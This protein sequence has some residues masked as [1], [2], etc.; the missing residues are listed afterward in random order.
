VLLSVLALAF[1]SSATIN[2]QVS[3]SSAGIVQDKV[4]SQGA[5]D[6]IVG[7]LRQ[8]VVDGTPASNITNLAPLTYYNGQ[9]LNLYWPQAGQYNTVM[10]QV[11]L[12]N[13][14]STATGM[15]N[16]VKE[17]AYNVSLYSGSAYANTGPSRASSMHTDTPSQNGHYFNS[18]RWNK[19]LLMQAS[20]V[21]NYQPANP[22]TV[23]DWVLVGRDGSN[24]LSQGSTA[25]FSELGDPS[26]SDY[27]VGRYAFTIYDEGSL[28]DANVAGFPGSL[29]TEPAMPTTPVLETASSS[30]K[31]LTEQQ[32]GPK[33]A[34]SFADLSILN[35]TPAQIDTLVGW[36]NHASSQPSGSFP[37]YSYPNTAGISN[38]FGS[39]LSN[40][41]G[42]MSLGNVVNANNTAYQTD[43]SFPTRQALLDFFLKTLN[44]NSDIKVLD[45]LQY[46][47]TH[48]IDINQPSYWPDPER[49][50]IVG[51]WVSGTINP[52]SPNANWS[53]YQGNNDQAGNDDIDNPSFL[54]I[55]VGAGGGPSPF[56]RID[57]SIANKGD[58][59]VNKRFP[60]CRLAWLT[61]LGPSAT[62][63][64]NTNA[65]YRAITLQG[66]GQ[67][68]IN[69]GTANNIYQA[70]GLTWGPAANH[71]NGGSTVNVGYCW[72]YSH[73]TV[74]P[75]HILTLAEVAAQG[76]D[77]D[78]FE[79]LKA[80]ICVGS[81]GKASATSENNAGTAGANGNS[82]DVG[83]YQ[84]AMDTTVD[85]QILQIGANIIDQ[86]DA[87]G[88]PTWIQFQNGSYYDVKDCF[89]VESLPYF[90]GVLNT[91]VMKTAPVPL[92]LPMAS[93]M[94]Q[95]RELLPTETTTQTS[96]PVLKASAALTNNGVGV[97]LIN[98]IL[99]NPYDAASTPGVPAPTQ[100]RFTADINDPGGL[101]VH[102]HHF[103]TGYYLS[104]GDNT[105]SQHGAPDVY[106]YAAG[107][108]DFT[109]CTLVWPPIG[110][111]PVSS[112]GTI[113][114]YS[115]TKLFPKTAN[116]IYKFYNET[117]V[118]NI[119]PTPSTSVLNINLGLANA[120][121]F[122]EPTVL[123]HMGTGEPYFT[124]GSGNLLASTV[125]DFQGNSLQLQGGS[126]IKDAQDGSIMGG[127]YTGTFP[128]RVQIIDPILGSANPKKGDTN[129]YIFT[130][131]GWTP[132][133]NAANT[134]SPVATCRLSYQSPIDNNF[135]TYDQKYV[136]NITGRTGYMI[137]ESAQKKVAASP[138]TGILY[139]DNW[140]YTSKSGA[141][142][143]EPR[144]GRFGATW[145]LNG[146]FFGI[147]GI[148]GSQSAKYNYPSPA[149]SDV[150]GTQRPD[151]LMNAYGSSNQG[152]PG[153][154]FGKATWQQFQQIG[155]YV[156]ES[157]ANANNQI[158]WSNTTSSSNQ[159]NNGAT[160][161]GLVEQNNPYLTYTQFQA[162]VKEF[163]EDPDKV[164]RRGM[165]AYTTNNSNNNGDYPALG[166]PA[167]TAVSPA[168]ELGTQYVYQSGDATKPTFTAQSR[169]VMLNRPFRSV[170][171]LGYVFRD[172]PY[173]NIDFFTPES[174]DAALLDVFCI[175][176]DNRSDGLIEG[177]IN[178][179]TKQ[180]LVLESILSGAYRDELAN[181]SYAGSPS[182]P[183]P[184]LS[185]AE[186]TSIANLLIN[187]TSST[188]QN[189]GQ[190]RNISE[191]VGKFVP[192]F[193]PATFPAGFP[194]FESGNFPYP[195][196]FDGFSNDLFSPPANQKSYDQSS[197]TA[198]GLIQRYLETAIRALADVG[199]TRT[200]NLMIDLVAQTG[201]YPLNAQ[202]PANGGTDHFIVDGEQRYWVHVAI[203]RYTGQVLDESVEQVKE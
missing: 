135:Y 9:K 118:G 188:S 22:F 187:R 32:L 34:E 152:N 100:L 112:V 142:F 45:A 67:Q 66:V 185:V 50:K 150:I 10:P 143:F 146:E 15:A 33:T 20:G 18:T 5:I 191:L 198:N 90:E 120:N 46:L 57:G 30:P 109:N 170:A 193:T 111:T 192:K 70:F 172:E 55:R 178:L 137:G 25:S 174:G 79:L 126:G 3:K 122:H 61:Y 56:V 14:T 81:L 179:N 134:P 196:D 39:V 180:P 145:P 155:W 62:Q 158:S 101:N 31:T 72:T 1:L 94:G 58:P 173:K 83:I 60:L 140:Q 37:N 51:K 124:I 27:V 113:A 103:Y 130:T 132:D 157:N 11:S 169:P 59:L 108:Q 7:D 199:T 151:N 116:A 136:P 96:P 82:A 177:K 74:T 194:Q 125:K 104:L 186:A 195:G 93:N 52:V 181:A 41:N 69:N 127:V 117:L 47:G 49:P 203:D 161:H 160:Y 171:D 200:W 149:P 182:N 84:Q 88:F 85:Y 97:A 35:L 110:S 189:M 175:D 87:D 102:G 16:L 183:P 76:R 17:S 115:A 44:G 53:N 168:G 176:E 63:F 98:P 80:A 64:A 128:M 78:F 107:S 28:L 48:D 106:S 43:Q 36:R 159:G 119:D 190:L 8:E 13:G 184:G 42:F 40:A 131:A 133:N 163:Y 147:A 89:G 164:I 92:P 166:L 6:T 105:T 123:C 12:A 2:R 65:T 29:G 75:P 77:P 54:S 86:F 144:S 197:G 23:P 21:G 201:R 24:P 141:H 68:T 26:K 129:L 148:D 138:G 73:S 4:F 91:T 156:G 38:Y 71:S 114:T 139:T 95:F 167:A 162:S 19:P 121:T 165:A 202:A 153:R 154:A 99:W